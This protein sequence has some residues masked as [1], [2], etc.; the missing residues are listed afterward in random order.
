[1]GRIAAC[2][3]TCI[4]LALMSG[5]AIGEENGITLDAHQKAIVDK[6][7][8]YFSG[9]HTL[10]GSFLQTSSDNRRMKGKFYVQRPGRF[11]FDYARPSRQ[12]VVSDGQTLAV[13]D[14]DLNNEDRVELDQTPFRLLLQSDVDLIRDAQ[15]MEVQQ[16]DEL[17]V[18]ALQAKDPNAGGQITLFLATKPELKL[19][20]WVT[21]D[22]QGIDTRV[23]IS[24]LAKGVEFDA[25]LFKIKPLA[26]VE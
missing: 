25:D 1:M 21:K 13:Q 3:A 12:I 19:K 7:S 22:A 17:I 15:I 8:S 18:L 23:E 9:I 11:R 24:D 5:T 4:G 2:V 6:V 20:A 10:Q 14:L 16:S 26:W